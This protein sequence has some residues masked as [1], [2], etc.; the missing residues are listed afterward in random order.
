[1]ARGE[2]GTGSDLDLLVDFTDEASALD[3]V[4]LRLALEELLGVEVDV[5]GADTLRGAAGARVL[6][7]ATP[8]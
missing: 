6:R 8:V 5:I 7:D 3:E 2:A 1:M 4:G